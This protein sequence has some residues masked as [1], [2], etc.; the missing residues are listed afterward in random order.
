[1]LYDGTKTFSK[2][3]YKHISRGVDYVAGFNSGN[4]HYRKD[5]RYF[6]IGGM[7]LGNP[8]RDQLINLTHIYRIDG[9]ILLLELSQIAYSRCINIDIG[10][11]ESFSFTFSHI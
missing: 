6:Q 10:I 8:S 3:I 4:S 7:Y 11:V 1:M 9:N 2:F 5:N